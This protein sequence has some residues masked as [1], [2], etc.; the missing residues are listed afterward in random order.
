[1]RGFVKVLL[2]GVVG[3]FVFSGC[4]LTGSVLADMKKEDGVVKGMDVVRASACTSGT[5]GYKDYQ[6]PDNAKQRCSIYFALYMTSK[7]AIENGYNYFLITYKSGSNKNPAPIVSIDKVVHYCDPGYFDKESNLLEDKCGH[8][9]LGNG[10]PSA[11]GGLKISFFK[12][13]NPFIPLW[14]ARKILKETKDELV[15]VCYADDPEGFQR[16]IEKSRFREE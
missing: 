5:N 14:D 3:A 2:V 16:A 4:A 6:D 13:R 7:K 11:F 8:I 9:G 10:Y 15:N 1:M 12:K